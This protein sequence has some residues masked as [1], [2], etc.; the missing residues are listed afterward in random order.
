M[1][2]GTVTNLDALDRL[3]DKLREIRELDLSILA[4]RIKAIIED[5]NR[6]GLL[7]GTDATGAPM[8]PLAEATI[9]SRRGGFGPPTVPRYAASG[10]IDRFRVRVDPTA[11]GMKITAG[12]GGD[13]PQV[14]FFRSGTKH[15]PARNPIGF[16]PETRA[17]I[18]AATEAFAREQAGRF[19]VKF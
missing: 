10:L 19:G 3:L 1:L 4:G 8:A 12:W 5:G 17:L 16:R 14:R 15:M 11:T 13:V 9:K 7:A 18:Q 2:T 6:E